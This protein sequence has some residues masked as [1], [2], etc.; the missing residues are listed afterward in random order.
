MA[1]RKLNRRRS[2]R[3]LSKTQTGG[4]N[5]N[6]A[7]LLKKNISE[8]GSHLPTAINSIKMAMKKY[9]ASPWDAISKKISEPQ[10]YKAQLEAYKKEFGLE[11]VDKRALCQTRINSSNSKYLPLNLLKS[12]LIELGKN[13]LAFAVIP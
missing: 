13:P 11:N 8:N 10:E 7:E 3:R 4:L 1:T 6:L 2:N 12:R 9:I 5:L